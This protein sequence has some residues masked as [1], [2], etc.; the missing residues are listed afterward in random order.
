VAASE[1]TSAFNTFQYLDQKAVLGKNYY[2]L[3]MVGE[4]SEETVI[5]WVDFEKVP[6]SVSISPNPATD[7]LLVDVSGAT[8]DYEIIVSDID[9]KLVKT[10]KADM[11][12][13]RNRIN[14][15]PLAAGVYT[16]QVK[17]GEDTYAERIS[18]IK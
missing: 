9:A 11:R 14:V 17:A 15:S 8:T 12:T 16:I 5:R 7:F 18:V 4:Q 6:F 2:K 13:L 3:N 10:E 1:V